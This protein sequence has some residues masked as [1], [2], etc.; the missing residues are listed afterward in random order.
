MQVAILINETIND[1]KRN[2]D[3]V[4]LNLFSELL[5]LNKNIKSQLNDLHKR[6]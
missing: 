1:P 6:I 2:K 5:I 4:E 3:K